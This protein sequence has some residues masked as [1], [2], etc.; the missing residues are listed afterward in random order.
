MKALIEKRN[1][2]LDEME[3]LVTKAESETRAFNEDENARL[4]TIK[5]EIAGID[6]TLKTQEELRSME[7]FKDTKKKED[8]EVEQRALDE[9]NFLKFIV[10]REDRALGTAANGGIIP[11]SIANRIIEKVKELSPIY[12]LVTVYNV[13]GDLIFPVYDEATSKISAA[14]SEDFAELTENTGKFTTVK[15]TN[16]IIGCLA[17]V[18]KSLINRTD[19][20]VASYVVKKVAEAIV[21]F[22]E[23]ELIQG[24]PG[25]MQGI[26]ST[27]NTVT[28]A[29]V[30][31]VDTDDLIDL[32]MSV[33]QVY[34]SKAVWIMHKNTLK[35]LR[36]LKDADKNYILNKDLNNGFGWDLLGRPVYITESADEAE[37]GNKAIFYGDMSGVALKLAQN[38]QIQVLVEKFATQHA[39]GVV[40]YVEADSKVTDNQKIAA[41]VIQ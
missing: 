39:I 24:T 19:F 25:K 13:G 38:M 40:G 6:K 31:V 20:D 18:S 4:D 12:N 9:E 34:Q 23:G 28:T 33:P 1:A 26:A 5:T 22:L 17:K 29:T 15:L 35:S 30:G 27:T 16:F 10:N 32:Q 3:G 2:L 21:E 37:T 8:P 11:T 14:Y 41:L 7:K 36:K